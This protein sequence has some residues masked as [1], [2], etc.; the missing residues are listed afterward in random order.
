M[1]SAST[2]FLYVASHTDQ[3]KVGTSRYPEWR[4]RRTFGAVLEYKAKI[5]DEVAADAEAYALDLLTPHQAPTS[6]WFKCDARTAVAA[7][8]EAVSRARKGEDL[9]AVNRPW[10]ANQ[11]RGLVR[12]A[13]RRADLT[14]EKLKIARELWDN[15]DYNVRQI[16]K[17]SGVSP[18]TLYQHMPDRVDALKRAARRKEARAAAEIEMGKRHA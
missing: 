11:R 3:V 10:L 6:E 4:A 8:K 9:K 17:I 12:N 14:K 2:T 5:A 7:V 13:Q 1:S 16:A 18:T 15:V